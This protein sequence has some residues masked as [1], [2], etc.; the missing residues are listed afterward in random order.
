MMRLLKYAFMEDVKLSCWLVSN[1]TVSIPMYSQNND[2]LDILYKLIN[3]IDPT[4]TPRKSLHQNHNLKSIS[5][6]TEHVQF[7]LVHC[8]ILLS[9]DMLGIQF[10][11]HIVFVPF[12]VGFFESCLLCVREL[13]RNLCQVF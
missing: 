2:F 13:W 10:S 5:D 8:N 12:I 11:L 3:I 4:T 6:Q 1:T 7:V 9:K